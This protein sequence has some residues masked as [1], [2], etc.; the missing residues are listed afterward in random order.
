VKEIKADV[1]VKGGAATEEHVRK[2]DG[3]PSTVAV[4]LLPIDPRFT[5]VKLRESLCR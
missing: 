1:V 2:V 5:S 4:K 3:I